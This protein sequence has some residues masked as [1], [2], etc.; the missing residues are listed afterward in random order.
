M[1]NRCGRI[2]G[3]I[4]ARASHNSGMLLG[5]V[6]K[7]QRDERA[8]GNNGLFWQ[9]APDLP[10]HLARPVDQGLVPF[11]KPLVIAFGWTEGGEKKQG[12]DPCCPWNGYEQHHAQPA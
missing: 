4:Q 3:G 6:K 2:Q 5:C 7:I 12:P 10:D 8:V 9:P 1:A 11:A